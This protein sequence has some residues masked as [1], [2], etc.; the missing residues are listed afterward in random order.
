MHVFSG[1]WGGVN[2]SVGRLK[3]Y[4]GRAKLALS[5]CTVVYMNWPHFIFSGWGWGYTALKHAIMFAT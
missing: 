3:G 5:N 2:S 1:K 4:Q